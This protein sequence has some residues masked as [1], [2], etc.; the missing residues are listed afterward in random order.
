MQHSGVREGALV[1]LEPVLIEGQ[2]SHQERKRGLFLPHILVGRVKD[3]ESTIR[4]VRQYFVGHT[5]L[6]EHAWRE[7]P[8]QQVLRLV[9]Q[10]W[11]PAPTDH[12]Q[13]RD[14]VH[15]GTAE[16][17]QRIHKVSKS[18]ILQVHAGDVSR[19]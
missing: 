5:H 19:G 4:V 12:Q 16:G 17:E 6:L 15:L 14:G 8:L 18:R 1:V 3:I 13:H 9:L 7:P 2:P 10:T 11:L